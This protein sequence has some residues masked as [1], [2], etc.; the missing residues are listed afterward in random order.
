MDSLHESI[1]RWTM[2]EHGQ[3]EHLCGVDEHSTCYARPASS[4]ALQFLVSVGKLGDPVGQHFIS[5][6]QLKNTS[7]PNQFRYSAW[8]GHTVLFV[9]VAAIGIRLLRLLDVQLG[10]PAPAVLRLADNL[11]AGL[12]HFAPK[13]FLVAAPSEL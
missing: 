6:I 10:F 11:H 9:S 3:K 2:K 1:S 7:T 8:P 12:R 4:N 5:K 13:T